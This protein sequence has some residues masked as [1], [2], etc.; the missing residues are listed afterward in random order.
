MADS[1][2]VALPAASA[3]DLD[4][5]LYFEE[6]G[7]AVKLTPAQLIALILANI[8]AAD[9]SFVDSN[10]TATDVD[11]A[12]AELYAS[13]TAGGGDFNSNTSSSVDSE[14]VLFSGTGG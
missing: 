1:T 7:V 2:L 9:I 4:D 12:L 11:G 8:G 5:L 3:P 10:F 13:I 6:D 14:I